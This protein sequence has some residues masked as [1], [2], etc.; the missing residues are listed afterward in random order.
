M[1]PPITN[2]A[3]VVPLQMPF[4]RVLLVDAEGAQGALV[5]LLLRT[6]R[7]LNNLTSNT[8]Y[9]TVPTYAVWYRYIYVTVL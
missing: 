2:L 7:L 6:A 9:G 4:E 3:L 8:V 5:I 1:D